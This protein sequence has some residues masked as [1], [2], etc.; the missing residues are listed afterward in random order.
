MPRVKHPALLA[1]HELRFDLHCAVIG[2]IRGSIRRN[3]FWRNQAPEK[4]TP[5]QRA[6]CNRPDDREFLGRVAA[7]TP[8]ENLCPTAPCSCSPSPISCPLPGLSGLA[9]GLKTYTPS[10]CWRDSTTAEVRFHAMPKRIAT[11]LYHRAR[12]YERRGS[13]DDLSKTAR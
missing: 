1:W 6:G 12:D 4:Q 8:T 9:G 2:P 13:L 11:K 5:P 3:H 10:P 7:A